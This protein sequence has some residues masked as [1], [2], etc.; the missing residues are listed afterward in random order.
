MV[1]REGTVVWIGRTFS[2]ISVTSTT[3]F[4]CSPRCLWMGQAELT[5]SCC[6]QRLCGSRV[7][8]LSRPFCERAY[9]MP[10]ALVCTWP[11]KSQTFVVH[12]NHSCISVSWIFF[13]HIYGSANEGACLIFSSLRFLVQCHPCG[14]CTKPG[15]SC[16]F[17]HSVHYKAHWDRSQQ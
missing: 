6:V 15:I 12:A 16:L 9:L 1:L 10:F 2:L 13:C 5:Q 17:L 8:H 4:L 11:G 7:E 14:A 3:A